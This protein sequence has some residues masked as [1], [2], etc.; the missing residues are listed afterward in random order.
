VVDGVEGEAEV[1]G[2]DG[3]ELKPRTI[4][5]DWLMEISSFSWF[6]DNIW[7]TIWVGSM[8]E[9]GSCDFSSVTSS[10]RKALSALLASE[11][12]VGFDEVGAALVGAVLA[13]GNVLV[14]G[15]TFIMVSLLAVLLRSSF[16]NYM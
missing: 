7:P 5:S 13:A 16:L 12:G 10:C 4:C 11:V 1:V 2:A 9:V 6:I 3:L 14:S 8:G 15:W